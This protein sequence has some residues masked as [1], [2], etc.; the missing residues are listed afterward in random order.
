VADGLVALR[1]DDRAAVSDALNL[2]LENAQLGRVDHLARGDPG[3]HNMALPVTRSNV[4]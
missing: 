2:A 3:A 1:H 4:P